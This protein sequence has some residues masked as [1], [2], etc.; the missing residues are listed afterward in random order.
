MRITNRMMTNNMMNNIN[1]NKNRVSDLDEQYASGKKIQRPSDDPIVA[2]RALKLR[3]NLSELNQYYKKNIP[4]AMSWMDVTESALD[5]INDTLKL[6]NT[7]CVQGTNDPLA[8]S[9]RASIVANLQ[10]YK[11]QIYQEGNSNYAGRYVFSGYKTDTSLIFNTES[12]NLKYSIKEKLSG[13][14]MEAIS[15]VV[16]ES[17]LDEYVATAPNAAVFA[18]APTLKETHRLRLAYDDLD[19]TDA[20]SVSISYSKEDTTSTPKTVTTTVINTTNTTITV[21]NK[22]TNAVISTA[23]N[24]NK[25]VVKTTANEEE[26]YTPVAGTINFIEETGELI[27]ADDVYEDLKSE[28]N[29]SVT[30]EKTKFKEGDLRPEHYFDCKVT[31]KNKPLQAAI[32]YT[33]ED[34]QIQYEINFNQKL[35]VNTQGSDALQHEIGR[36]IDEIL[37]AVKDV[38]ETEGEIAEVEDMLK[39]A[40]VTTDQKTALN[41]LLKQLNTELVLKNKIMHN[42]FEKAITGTSEQQ[43]TMNVAV[44]DLGSRYVRLELTESRLS[45]QQGDYVDLLSKNED[46]DVVET[47]ISL[48]AAEVIY[49]ASL[50]ATAKIAKTT[51]LDF[52]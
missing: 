46:A 5:N 48:T 32:E 35:T 1:K 18:D 51:L 29:L 34:Q 30:Y 37:D 50:S 44:A 16:G 31:D 43:N 38:M 3:T 22:D 47:Y 28:E 20:G 10:Q 36:D 7:A 42:K 41:A 11:Q 2:A 49:N 8:V 45:S 21:T 14:D 25:I 26:Y 24:A 13:S 17:S 12:T 23:T 6:I 52:L 19:A 15:K 4:D 33:K 40:D 39:E 9:D 27:P